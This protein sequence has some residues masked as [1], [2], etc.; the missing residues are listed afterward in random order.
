VLQVEGYEIKCFS[1]RGKRLEFR[2]DDDDDDDDTRSAPIHSD[3]N[4]VVSSHCSVL[5]GRIQGL[6][7]DDYARS[8][9]IHHTSAQDLRGVRLLVRLYLSFGVWVSVREADSR[10]VYVIV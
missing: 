9:S 8:A 4:L 3:Q 6:G 10:L 1:L 5:R 2:D 7:G